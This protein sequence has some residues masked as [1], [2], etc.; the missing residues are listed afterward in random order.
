MGISGCS[1]LD[2]TPTRWDMR[3]FF[4]HPPFYRT[5]CI[6]AKNL[7]GEVA[8]FAFQEAKCFSLVE[9][10]TNSGSRSQEVFFFFA[11]RFYRSFSVSLHCE[12]GRHLDCPPAGSRRGFSPWQGCVFVVWQTSIDLTKTK[13]IKI[14]FVIRN[15]WKVCIYIG[16][17][18]LY[19]LS[20]QI[21][22]DH[23]TV[24]VPQISFGVRKL[25]GA[26]SP[27][28]SHSR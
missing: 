4:K 19:G 20:S 9:H 27:M 11:P 1:D 21:F 12:L 3:I 17:S 14:S 28:W 23:W 6:R 7:N 24:W 26:S 25:R 18:P 10:C 16:H 15:Y 8:V 13:S 22:R 2:E 5:L